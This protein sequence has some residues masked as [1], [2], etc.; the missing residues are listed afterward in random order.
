MWG[1]YLRW[2]FCS[3]V[4]IDPTGFVVNFSSSNG[5]EDAVQFSRA[6]VEEEEDHT[7]SHML[8]VLKMRSRE[9]EDSGAEAVIE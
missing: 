3:P 2:E 4:W 5:S 1:C 8:H 9:T 7:R 6:E